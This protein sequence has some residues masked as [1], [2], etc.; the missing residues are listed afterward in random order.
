[1][2]TGDAPQ[3]MRASSLKKRISPKV[4]RTWS[5]WSRSYSLL[6]ATRSSTIP[7]TSM[8]GTTNAAANRKEP[9]WLY[10]AAA[11]K[12]PIMYMEPWARFTKFMM[13]NTSVSPAAMR[14][15]R[16]PNCRPLSAWIMK[17]LKLTIHPCR[18]CGRSA[19]TALGRAL[20]Q[21]AL[22]RKVSAGCDMHPA[23]GTQ[24]GFAVFIHHIH[25]VERRV[26]EMVGIELEVPPD[27]I[28]IGFFECCNKGLL[29][30]KIA[31]HLL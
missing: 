27:G 24:H 31:A 29:V 8:M 22:R 20:L 26:G 16:T 18:L 9:V 7:N 6:S 11:M 4:A 23:G 15:R 14:N 13:P 2:Y 3:I 21:V 17:R 1:M 5:R 10:K 28:E 25:A 30:G 19:Q 12:A